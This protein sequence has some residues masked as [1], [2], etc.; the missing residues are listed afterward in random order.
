MICLHVVVSLFVVSLGGLG[1]GSWFQVR[2]VFGAFGY[3]CMC[4]GFWVFGCFLVVSVW[5]WML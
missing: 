5:L 3:C 2:S 1:L 4:C